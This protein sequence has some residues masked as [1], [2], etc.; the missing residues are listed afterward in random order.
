M[1]VE[2]ISDS[3]IVEK[4]LLTPPPNNINRY[5]LNLKGEVDRRKTCQSCRLPFMDIN[6]LTA[7]GFFLTNRDNVAFC[8]FCGVEVGK[9]NE[10]D[11]GFKNHQR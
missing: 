11:D 10:G 5:P 1:C 6:Q 2:F 9:W 7:A 4:A 8:A 3:E